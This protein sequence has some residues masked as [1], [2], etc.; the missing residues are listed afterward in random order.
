MIPGRISGNILAIM[1]KN[2][3]SSYDYNTNL[4]ML[5]NAVCTISCE[6]APTAD[7]ILGS[8]PRSYFGYTNTP[9]TV[10][11]RRYTC[12]NFTLLDDTA[13]VSNQAFLIYYPAI[14]EIPM[15]LTGTAS[16]ILNPATFATTAQVIA[17]LNSY[18]DRNLIPVG[19][20][21]AIDKT[22]SYATY[23]H[24]QIVD[25]AGAVMPVTT[26]WQATLTITEYL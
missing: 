17:C 22:Q 19:A 26:K 16:G 3:S 2:N 6:G 25:R 24:F 7:I 13:Y 9:G 20:L 14:D 18:V 21:F 8:V 5:G 23:G 4:S 12:Q 15:A 11:F 1:I 10:K